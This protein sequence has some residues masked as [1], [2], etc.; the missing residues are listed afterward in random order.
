MKKK[1]VTVD[2]DSDATDDEWT[3]EEKD[4]I[5]SNLKKFFKKH[6]SKLKGL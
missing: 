4:L 6:F 5:A 2:F 3:S 1:K